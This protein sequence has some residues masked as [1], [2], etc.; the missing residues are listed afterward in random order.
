M[1][2]EGLLIG[3]AI[4][5]VG[6]AIL[7]RGAMERTAGSPG[8]CA[9]RS[10]RTTGWLGVLFGIA[11]AVLSARADHWTEMTPR[12]VLAWMLDSSAPATKP[13]GTHIPIPNDALRDSPDR[14]ERLLWQHQLGQSMRAWYDLA[15][16]PSQ[17]QP[18][19]D[20]HL[21]MLADAAQQMQDLTSQW[22]GTLWADA[23]PAM[24]IRRELTDRALAA[25]PS[26]LPYE[27]WAASELFNLNTGTPEKAIGFVPPPAE[28]LEA[29]ANTNDPDAIRYAI[30]R[31]SVIQGDP[32][33]L[34]IAR[35]LT[36]EDP[37]IASRAEQAI[38]WRT[39]IRQW[40]MPSGI[41]PAA[42]LNETP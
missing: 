8:L 35:F 23:W 36:H 25:T 11:L 2:V 24:R 33:S 31:A 38:E 10:G 7:V 40:P 34:L 5:G 16:A 18:S 29:I 13:F 27:R 20:A 30:D 17:T 12:P 37:T 28:V 42:P 4:L 6:I 14:F 1:V 22:N 32:Y 19:P 9:S 26:G 15:T 39:G 41:T 3:G 21:I